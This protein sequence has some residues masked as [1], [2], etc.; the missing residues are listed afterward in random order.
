MFTSTLNS[1][2][3]SIF[4]MINKNTFQQMFSDINFKTFSSNLLFNQFFHEGTYMHLKTFTE[5]LVVQWELSAVHEVVAIVRE[6][7]FYF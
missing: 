4:S 5:N 3:G 7:V 1:I 6:E 2:L